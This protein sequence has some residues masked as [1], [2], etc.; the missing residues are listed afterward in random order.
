MTNASYFILGSFAV[1]FNFSRLREKHVQ[2]IVIG[3]LPLFEAL[4][5]P[6]TGASHGVNMLFCSEE[7][8]T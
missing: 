7:T 5:Y 8:R 6:H 4:Y 2:R 1:V 3:V